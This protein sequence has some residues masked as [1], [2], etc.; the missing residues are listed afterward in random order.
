MW[1]ESEMKQHKGRL[2]C[3]LLLLFHSLFAL[4]W[5]VVLTK[6]AVYS[7][8]TLVLTQSGIGEEVSL[9]GTS[10]VLLLAALSLLAGSVLLWIYAFKKRNAGRW[11]AVSVVWLLANALLLLLLPSQMY[12]VA[13]YA[14]LRPL[15]NAAW[16]AYVRFLF[17]QVFFFVISAVF[18]LGM[19]LPRKWAKN[20]AQT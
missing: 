10:V 2:W 19:V 14:I 20:T 5:T 3:F 11:K 15:A 7:M 13:R 18:A 9:S 6:S 16:F 4:F 12:T 8:H 1:G 17:S